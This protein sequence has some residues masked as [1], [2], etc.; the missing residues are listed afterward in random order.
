MDIDD[1][2]SRIFSNPFMFKTREE[3]AASKDGTLD[4]KL[5]ETA[6]N[7]TGSNV[8]NSTSINTVWEKDGVFT[9]VEPADLTGY[10]KYTI[11]WYNYGKGA[12]SEDGSA[13]IIERQLIIKSI[14]KDDSTDE[15]TITW[16]GKTYA[17][18]DI[19]YREG[20]NY[21]LG[22]IAFRAASN[23][24]TVF[25]P[26]PGIS[27]IAKN[28]E[29]A[30]FEAAIKVDLG[31]YHHNGSWYQLSNLIDIA[32][33]QGSTNKVVTS[34]TVDGGPSNYVDVKCISTGKYYQT[35]TEAR[36]H[37]GQ[38]FVLRLELFKSENKGKY[39]VYTYVNGILIDTCE[40]DEFEV[41]NIKIEGIP[42]LA[43][44]LVV[45]FSNVKF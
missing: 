4:F 8:N 6:W 11:E 16:N 26:A 20:N 30:S 22:L 40:V 14:V 34:L 9:D 25:A 23:I 27:P 45:T 41:S 42:A 3:V 35:G 36:G 28:G 24:S 44:D 18:G 19:V 32:I 1:Q 33:R 29:I 43:R 13:Y 39:I 12:A 2:T 17:A 31:D 5:S 21:W 38:E 10:T 15:A 37:V 7:V